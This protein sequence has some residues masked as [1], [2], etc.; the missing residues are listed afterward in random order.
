MTFRN[1]IS[2]IRQDWLRFPDDGVSAISAFFNPSMMIT[3]W[4]RIGSWLFSKHNIFARIANIP[5]RIIYKFNGLLTGIQLPLGTRIG[6]GIRFKHFSCI[7]IAQSSIIG[8]CATIHQGV[9]IGRVFA[10]KKA[11]VPTLADHVVVFPGAKIVGNVHVGS[12]VVIGANAVVVDNVPDYAV[13]A[14]V[15]ARIVSK[16]SRRCF[17]KHWSVVHGFK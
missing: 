7:V 4:F 12:H 11:G 10:G 1:C 16:D 15:P 13:V 17:D 2:L 5:V 14:G 6:G 9:T 8:E 3:F